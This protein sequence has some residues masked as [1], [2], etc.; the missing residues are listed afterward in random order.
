MSFHGRIRTI[1]V[2]ELIDI[3]RDR[4]TLIAMILV[5]IVLYPLLMLGSVQALSYQ[6]ESLE[7]EGFRIGVV[8]EMQKNR[9]IS[10]IQH[11]AVA[12]QQTR[13]RFH[14]ESEE[15]KRLPSTPLVERVEVV[16]PFD[17]REE[18]EQAISDRTI[19]IGVVLAN[20]RLVPPP[21]AQNEI[22]ILA[23][24]TE[25]RSD[26]AQR[27][28]SEMIGRFRDRIV[29]NRK[30]QLNLADLFDRPFSVAV[31]DLSAP[32]SVLG[33][34][35]PLILVLM[36]ITGAIYPAIDLTAGERER[37]TLESLMVS[38]VSIFDLIVGKFLVVTTVA[39]MGATLNLAS[40]S[41]TVYFGG[42]DQ[43]IS[44]SG[45]SIPYA[46]MLFI[47]LCLIP[48]AVLMSAIMLAVCSYARTFKEA[49]NYV[50]PV[51]MAVLI[52]GGIAAMPTTRMEG[53]MLVMPVSNMVLLARDLL[54]GA[55]VPWWNVLTVLLST[56]LYAGAAVAVA[57][58][59]FGTESVV[60]A[61]AGSWKTMFSRTLRKPSATP[62]IA[63]GLTVVALLFPTWFFVQSAL[64][65]GPGEDATR[66]L[67][68]SG[69][70]MPLLFVLLPIGLL[71]YAKVDIASTL[72]LR[73]PSGRYLLAGVL[74]GVSAWVPAHELTVLQER[75]F[76]VPQIVV[77]SASAMAAT[78]AVLPAISVFLV[79]AIIPAVT[80]EL[81]FRGFLL[82]SIRG[83][84]GKWTTIIVSAAIFGVFHFFLFK[85]AV[86]ATLGVVLAYIC[87]QSRSIVP[88]MV[89][90]LL[91]NGI[92]AMSVV[93]ADWPTWIGLSDEDWVH[94]PT[95]V[96]I[97]GGVVFVLGLAIASRGPTRHT[98]QTPRLV[99]DQ[100]GV[101]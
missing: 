56:T 21:S 7:D 8:G 67:Q 5:P 26:F 61:D 46:T 1:Y 14:P 30:R 58:S 85:F 94:F 91:H 71:K 59:I 81:L 54:L 83:S 28:F 41:A 18:L 65:P 98:G 101:S 99:I 34:I 40:V 79:I 97:I 19:Q 36:T 9:V 72:A 77:D 27:Q 76:G 32:S 4:R 47:L 6:K 20:E 88:A 50:T 74:L 60:F 55:V 68:A 89:M 64:S 33:Q 90:H 63:M 39:I 12:W 86:T 69:W 42:F 82:S 11:G 62:S 10:L 16:P 22:E 31:T 29:E 25:I 53:V 95:P 43:V 17:T 75:V 100:R 35:L 44:S 73:M 80:E 52:P 96:L 49:Q 93:N 57:A 3:L 24:V 70:L 51:I 92:G 15:A 87:W 23:D 66:L 37:G 45:E 84:A 38:P 78:L 13:A 2:K 48:F